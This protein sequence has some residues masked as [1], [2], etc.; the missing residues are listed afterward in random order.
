MRLADDVVAEAAAFAAVRSQEPAEHADGGGLAAAVG[1]EEAADL[2][3]RDREIEAL[4]HF[5]V[6]KTLAQPVHVDGGVSHGA[7]AVGVG[8]GAPAPPSPAGRD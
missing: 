3:F 8:V 2:P 5:Q 4:D 7:L 6:A 1:A